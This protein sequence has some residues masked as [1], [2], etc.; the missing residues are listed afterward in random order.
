MI[1]SMIKIVYSC[2]NNHHQHQ[3]QQKKKRKGNLTKVEKYNVQHNNWKIKL[4]MK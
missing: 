3:Q 2:D 4:I 1:H